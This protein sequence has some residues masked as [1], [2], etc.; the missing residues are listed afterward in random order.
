MEL[1]SG[2]SSTDP[3]D[4]SDP[5]DSID[6]GD[7]FLSLVVGVVIGAGALLTLCLFIVCGIL[8]C[9]FTKDEGNFSVHTPPPL[10]GSTHTISLVMLALLIAQ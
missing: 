10:P 6:T 5:S 7:G 1:G 4:L 8:H 2:G 3:A 9:Y